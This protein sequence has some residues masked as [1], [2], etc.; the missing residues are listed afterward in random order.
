MKT[1]DLSAEI[2][3]LKAKVAGLEELLE[4]YERE[5]CKKSNSLEQA[6]QEL[7]HSDEELRSLKAILE[8]IGEGLVV[9]DGIGNFLFV[10]AAAEK[11]LGFQALSLPL[12][13]WSDEWLAAQGIFEAD[14]TTPMTIA[15]FPLLQAMHGQVINTTELYICPPGQ[16]TGRWLSVTARSLHQA[17]QTTDGVVA[18]F[19]DITHSKKTE[20]AL[21][22]A[23]QRSRQ[24]TLQLEMALLELQKAQAQL[25][26][27]EKMSGLEQ[28]IAGIAHEINNPVSF[29]YGNINPA[30][31]YIEDLFHV[32]RL[33]EHHYPEPKPVIRMALEAIDL[34]FVERDLPKLLQSMQLGADRI[35]KIVLSLRNFV[36]LDEAEKKAV[37][38]HEGLDNT[39]MLLQ[40]RLQGKANIPP[41]QIVKHYG[42]L[43]PIICYAGQLNQVFMNIL[44]NAIDAIAAEFSSVQIPQILEPVGAIAPTKTVGSANTLELSS[45]AENSD[46]PVGSPVITIRTEIRQPNWVTIRIHNTGKS[47]PASIR[48]RI[49]DPFFTTKPVG[50]GTGLG[51]YISYQIV[52]QH[53]QGRLNCLSEPGQGAEFQIEIPIV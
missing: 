12:S 34:D 18:F 16:T 38:L 40:S 47:I 33:Y 9:V 43:P 49:F 2:E 6:L 4:T 24:Q 14:Q 37:N 53:H 27:T 41:I 20:A 26:Q 29:I 30:R 15:A 8:S 50:Q 35:R 39:I 52:T 46:R 25:I 22:S 23:E 7:R 32:L 5:T 51:L 28:L 11:V 21:R 19:H 1:E 48:N 3:Q 36:R 31:S 44:N 45:P 17:D 13:Q 10:N 42:D